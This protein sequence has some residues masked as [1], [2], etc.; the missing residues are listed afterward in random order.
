MGTATI[1]TCEVIVTVVNVIHPIAS[2]PFTVFVNDGLPH[3]PLAVID[4]VAGASAG[5]P[6]QVTVIGVLVPVATTVAEPSHTPKQLA[7][8]T[9]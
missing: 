7:F 6:N 4:A 9:V 3:N 1:C 5:G 8:V 2:T